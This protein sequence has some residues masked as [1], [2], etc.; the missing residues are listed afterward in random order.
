VRITGET[1]QQTLERRLRP[2]EPAIR[3]AACELSRQD[4]L[5]F[6]L[7]GDALVCCDPGRMFEVKID[8]GTT[9]QSL[10]LLR[11]LI[12]KHGHMVGRRIL[13]DPTKSVKH[14]T[15]VYLGICIHAEVQQFVRTL[16]AE[17][18]EIKEM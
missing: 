12:L 5:D 6:S 1:L 9:D 18:F 8:G 15:V 4:V 11:Q 10:E 14:G 17:G 3:C 13:G 16:E 2:V 7:D